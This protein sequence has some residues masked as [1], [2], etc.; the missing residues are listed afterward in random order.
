MLE[1]IDQL[2]VDNVLGKFNFH[3][4]HFC[5]AH[6]GMAVK[7]NISISH[8]LTPKDLEERARSLL[9]GVASSGV[10]FSGC[11]VKEFVSSRYDRELGLTATRDESGRLHLRF[12][13][14][15]ASSE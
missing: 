12:S 14:F 4:L 9:E 1:N 3:K 7:S 10:V 8:Y 13:P 5:L 15:V 6:L 11:D 2:R